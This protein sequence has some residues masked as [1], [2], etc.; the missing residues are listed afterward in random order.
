MCAGD[1]KETRTTLIPVYLQTVMH[2]KR[3]YAQLSDE[4]L[5]PPQGF[6]REQTRVQSLGEMV[7]NE[8]VIFLY[9]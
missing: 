9:T 2:T 4:P 8:F 6:Q 7:C 1:K 5:S 3:T